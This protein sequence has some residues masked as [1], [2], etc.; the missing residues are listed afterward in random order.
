MKLLTASMR[1]E[2]IRIIRYLG[3][4]TGWIRQ[5]HHAYRWAGHRANDAKFPEIPL[6][7]MLVLDELMKG[8]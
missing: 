6:R 4:N 7:K 1:G 2:K 5:L 8:S 3:V